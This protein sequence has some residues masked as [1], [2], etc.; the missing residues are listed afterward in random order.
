MN[1]FID[2]LFFLIRSSDIVGVWL[3]YCIYK[4]EDTDTTQWILGNGYGQC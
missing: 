1:S 2:P 3:K 4:R